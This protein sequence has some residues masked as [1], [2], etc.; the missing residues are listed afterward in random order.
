SELILKGSS[1]ISLSAG[2]RRDVFLIFK[3]IVHNAA[4]H[5]GC[6]E[7]HVE[8]VTDRG[9]LTLK[10][11]D[12]GQ[13]FDLHAGTKHRGTGLESMRRRV[14]RLGGRLTITSELGRGTSIDLR[15]PLPVRTYL[16]V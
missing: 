4:K 14:E 2:Q 6:S 1:T 15:I 13:G 12:N 5:S 10:V 11:T 3:E 9:W 7:V 8:I 16:R